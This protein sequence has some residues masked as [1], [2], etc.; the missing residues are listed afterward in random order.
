M[1]GT[2]TMAETVSMALAELI[3]KAEEQGDVSVLREGVRVLSQALVA[4]VREGGRVVS[5]AVVLATGVR[6]SGE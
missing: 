3:R 1:K 6:S 2:T 4:V 5:M